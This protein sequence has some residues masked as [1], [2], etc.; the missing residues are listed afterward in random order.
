MAKDSPKLE[1]QL[2]GGFSD[3]NGIKTENCIL[4][5]SDF[6]IRTR[7]ALVNT[8]EQIINS[9]YTK[10]Q[11]AYQLFL[12]NILSEV[13]IREVDWTDEYDGDEVEDIIYK[14]IR[15]DG[16]DSVLTLLEYIAGQMRGFASKIFPN[17]TYSNAAQLYNDV[18]KRE[19]VGYR[20]VDNIIVPITD[21]IELRAVS[22]SLNS[23]F[24]EIQQ[25]F[26]KATAFLADR[27]SPDYPNSIKESISAVERMC[28]IILGKSST[29][30]AALKQLETQ[31]VVIH[32]SLKTAFDKLY[33]Y[34]SDGSGIRH[35]GQLGGPDATFEEAE[36][37]LVACSAFVNYLTMLYSKC[38]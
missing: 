36:F 8:T 20:F 30:G 2:R 4:Q 25:H 12:K 14:T 37:M 35:A 9:L 19:Y 6:D 7:T 10:N 18:F 23:N 17:F 32:P 34:T 26:K 3:R 16:Y 31:G 15:I 29:L 28:S 24:K 11:R 5:F 13:Y 38:K 33:G 21:E 1:V 27:V 22:D